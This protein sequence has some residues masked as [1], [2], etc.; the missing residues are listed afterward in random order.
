MICKFFRRIGIAVYH[1]RELLTMV[2]ELQKKQ[3]AP[4]RPAPVMTPVHGRGEFARVNIDQ[5]VRRGK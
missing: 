3:A 1:E 5:V 2:D 4:P